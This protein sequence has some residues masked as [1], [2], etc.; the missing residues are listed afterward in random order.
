MGFASRSILV[1]SMFAMLSSMSY[2]QQ[3]TLSGSVMDQKG[4][5]IPGVA[6]SLLSA[7]QGLT[8]EATS[9]SMGHFEI[10]S[11]RPGH[12]S[13]RAQHDGFGTTEINNL[14]VLVGQ[15]VSLKIELKVGTVAEHV[16]VESGVVPLLETETSSAGSIVTPEQIEDMP[17]NGRNYLD[18]MQLVPGVVVNREADQGNDDA[19]PV[20]G[21]RSGNTLFLLDG[22]P[23]SDEVNGGAAAQFNQDSI[24]EFQVETSGY[25]A[26]YG[27]GS[28]GVVNVVS[29]SGTNDFHGGAS[30]FHRNYKLDSSNVTGES[31]APFLLRWDPTVYL[32]G[33][34]LKDKVFFFGSAERI[35]E[36]RNLNF[37]F[38]ASTPPVIEQL[39][40]PFN[41]NSNIYV[42]RVR[43][44]LD[45]Q[46]GRH[47]FI[48]Q[49]NLTNN[50]VTD[51]LPLSAG[52]S[53]PDTRNNI[54]SRTLMLGFSDTVPLG[55]LSSPVLL[56]WYVQYRGEPFHM[57]PSHAEAGAT[58]INQ[59]LFSGP[60]IPFINGDEGIIRHGPS[61][62]N[63]VIDQNYLSV[64]ANFAKQVNRHTF[65][66]GWDYQHMHVNGLEPNNNFVQ[67]YGQVSDIPIYGPL[68][69]AVQLPTVVGGLTPQDNVIRLRNHYN[70]LFVQDDWKV[71]HKLALN[72]GV[73]WDYDTAFPNKTNFS[74]RLGFAWSL[75][76]NTVVRGSWGL[77]YD[78]FRLGLA[79]Y[80]PAFGGANLVV[81]NSLSFPRLFYGNPG[82]LTEF[83]VANGQNSPCVAHDQTDAQVAAAGSQCTFHGNVLAAPFYGID[84]LNDT[85]APG[86]APIPA[87]AV[88]DFNNVQ[89]LT[90]LTPQ[91]FADAASAAINEPAGYFSYDPFGHLSNDT[92]CGPRAGVPITLDKSFSTPYTSSFSLQVQHQINPSMMI[93]ATYYRKDIYNI[94]GIRDTNLAF[95]ARMPGSFAQLIPGTGKQVIFGFGPW[96]QGTYNG[97]QIGLKKRMSNRFT[98]QASYNWAHEID[99]ALNSNLVNELQAG[100]SGGAG[101]ANFFAPD[102]SFVGVPGVVVDSNSGQTNANSSFINS[103]GNFVPKAGVF[104]N[105]PAL[106]SGPSDLSRNHIFLVAGI[107]DLPWKF[108]FSSIFL[109]ESGF[110]YTA[111][112]LNGIDEDGDGNFSGNDFFTGRNHFTAPAYVNVDVRLGKRFD[113]TE[114]I[115]LNL[116]F[117]MF[118]LFNRAHPAAIQNT[119]GL[120]NSP[121][122]S[123]AS[124]IFGQPTQFL[125]GREG[126]VGVR[127][128]F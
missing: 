29:K 21:E 111:G 33:P 119:P 48:E 45:E 6:I 19:T 79:R 31:S 128:E 73:R 15:S 11:V 54:G 77:F 114:R 52:N 85:V 67:V 127:F 66:F 58:Q 13:L 89:A 81:T 65:K 64:G 14:V 99:D 36:V 39:E 101:L 25:K 60:S 120:V 47:H 3:V 97:I 62:D 16:T 92:I 113:L 126:Q 9:D 72:L 93:E 123:G 10:L 44:K 42:T 20:L 28:G 32:G 76:P 75:T 109:A 49:V 90:G 74:P 108:K 103:L 8:R 88:V 100:G 30:F 94:L 61:Y 69:S 18:L 22:M 105:G 5:V 118:N 24:L 98:L 84:H 106:D 87:G 78:H 1:V 53:L 56:N 71:N 43:G 104:F 38:P 121:G 70:G 46:L 83:L 82:T 40:E 2:A 41:K 91:Q 26:E 51:S 124:Q 95:E 63:L 34:I 50:H 37:Q 55:K 59:N 7:E 115:K 117:E 122:L 112:L 96:F 17:L 125:P 35:R 23:N 68:D 12:Y 116:Y 86:H 57:T 80:I 110:H 102:D 107:L 27:H 4:G